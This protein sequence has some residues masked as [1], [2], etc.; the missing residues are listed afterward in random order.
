MD[1]VLLQRLQQ[2]RVT[3][4]EFVVASIISLVVALVPLAGQVHQSP[5]VPAALV[6]APAVSTGSTS[7]SS[8]PLYFVENDGQTNPSVGFTV[9]G[10][11]QD[12]YFTDHGITRR[13]TAGDKSWVMSERFVGGSAQPIGIDH[14][15]AKFSWFNG[16]PSDWIRGAGSFA[17]VRYNDLWPGI[18]LVYH[19]TPA[20]LRHRYVVHA[21][22]DPSY[23]RT[24][25][26]G[27]DVGLMQDGSV[28]LST[29]V[30]NF[31]ESAPVAYQGSK[32]GRTDVDAS[33][34]VADSRTGMVTGT[35]DMSR[36][37]VIDP[38]SVVYSGF[39]GGGASGLTDG[40]D[41][42][43]GVVVDSTGAYV[44]GYTM[45]TQTTFPTSVGP[46]L[47][48]NN[49]TTGNYDA[50][51]AKVAPSGSSLLYSGYIGGNGYDR[52]FAIA[53]DS[54]GSAYVLGET[55]TSSGSFPVLGG[56]D[57]S[58][59]GGTDAFVAKVNPG[60]TSLTYAGYYGGSDTE[61]AKAIVV[62]SAGAAYIT[63]YTLSGQATFPV[64]SG[65]DLTFN[66][67]PGSNPDAFVAKIAPSGVSLSF[68]GYIGGSS[69][70]TAGGIAVDGTGA[71]YVVGNT[72]S[73]QATFPTSGGP[74]VTFNGTGGTDYDA[75]IAKVVPG[76]TSLSYAGFIGGGFFMEPA[77]VAVDSSGAAYVVGTAGSGLPVIVGPSL[78]LGGN[79]DAF[80]TKVVPSGASLQYSGYIGGANADHATGVA[81]DVTGA[82]TVVGDT[83]GTELGSPPFPA[84]GGADLTA[85]GGLDAFYA[86]VTPSG[87]SLYFASF[88]GGSGNDRARA[89]AL[90]STG[91]AYIVGD[92]TSS[93]ATFPIVGGLDSTF[94]GGPEDAFVAKVVL[95]PETFIDSGPNAPNPSTSAAFSFH[96]DD[97]T[98]TF[99]CRLDGG[100]F[101]PCSSPKSYSGLA[102]G[103]HDFVVRAV[104]T[105]GAP[106]PSASSS[107]WTVDTVDPQTTLDSGPP[108]RY[109]SQTADFTFTSDEPPATFECRLNSGSWGACASPQQQPSTAS[110]QTF[111]IRAVDAAGN[112]DLTPV[113]AIWTGCTIVGTSGVDIIDSSY[114]TPPTSG[115]DIIC[116]L[117]GNDTVASSDG[118]DVIDGGSG[119][120]KLTYQNS[121][122]GG[123]TGSLT[124]VLPE[125][126]GAFIDSQTDLVSG[127]EDVYGTPSDDTI[128]GDVGPNLIDGQSGADVLLGGGGDDQIYGATG[129]DTLDPG[130]GTD[131]ANGGDGFD[132]V[133]Y[134][135]SPEGI[136]AD[137][138]VGAGT[139][140]VG[141]SPP[142][143]VPSIEEV[144]GSGF[145]DHL[146]GGNASDT[147]VGGDGG[148]VIDGAIGD[149]ILVGESGADVMRGK[150]NDDTLKGGPGSDGFFGGSGV[151]LCPDF[152]ASV[153]SKAVGCKGHSRSGG[154]PSIELLVGQFLSLF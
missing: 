124:P 76:G 22:A 30:D 36:P 79:T 72:Q 20:G 117:G 137:L 68:S 111:D 70:E 32:A 62:D 82:A 63:G 66:G 16:R 4:R 113:S 112:I 103:G 25:Y 151:N 23:I 100:S 152:K 90:D 38:V 64:A 125:T 45:S 14:Q 3:R 83:L 8:I 146:T 24:A 133:T 1:V 51:V 120:D 104:D 85:N 34:V 129:K 58:L 9:D 42:A 27:A 52:G 43:Q 33:I 142:D 127:F 74:D 84:S 50:F 106:D 101:A 5:T 49:P 116:A 144:V 2:P 40:D 150:A 28:R 89:V 121:T 18:D 87:A 110:P 93:E 17:G 147:L 44:T 75:F 31:L 136:T 126:R 56:P 39:I 59:N 119:K 37:L 46:D 96:S 145:E 134:E 115:D 102:Q 65:P 99:E 55:N 107:S 53:V 97:G 123:V 6:H 98:A 88:F 47:S 61:W 69:N 130:L 153:D 35:Y 10:Q 132:I 141:T 21:G 105:L 57:L 78:T 13:L 67:V 77:G 80:I 73:T 48:F 128:E 92:T 131:I 91:Q 108:T 95:G 94:N 154:S 15:R 139:V 149:D 71:A 140:I 60:G 26:F 114:V 19:E 143:S 41:S 7:R 135:D 122:L 109:A 29:P 54:S 138:G 148:D 118:A 11:N 81:V 12:L 86:K